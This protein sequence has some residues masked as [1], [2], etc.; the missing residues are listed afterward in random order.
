VTSPVPADKS[1][2]A[3]ALAAFISYAKQDSEK[4]QEIADQLEEHGFKCWIAPRDV[5]PGRAY[6]DEIIRGI[7]TPPLP[8]G[9]MQRW[10]K[11]SVSG[12]RANTTQFGSLVEAPEILT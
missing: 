10:A 9:E 3:S 4:A 11:M 5:R 6:G 12:S 7:A 2:K 8:T 1:K